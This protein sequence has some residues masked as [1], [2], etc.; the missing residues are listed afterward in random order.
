M[1]Y[2]Y[3]TEDELKTIREAKKVMKKIAKRFSKFEEKEQKALFDE[4]VDWKPIAG[5]F[6]RFCDEIDSIFDYDGS[7]MSIK[8]D[9]DKP[10]ISTEEEGDEYIVT[11]MID[12][13]I[14]IT[15]KAKN[16]EEA[17]EK[18]E[19]EFGAADLSKANFCDGEI[20]SIKDKDGNFIE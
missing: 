16:I 14:P 12:G 3:I 5:Q 11:F 6:H 20:V 8:V 13:R 1:K 19:E 10:Q 15:V 18:A 2:Q 17:K 4:N 7:K 9:V